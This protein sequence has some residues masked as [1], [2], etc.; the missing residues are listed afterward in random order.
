MAIGRQD[1]QKQRGGRR[2][3]RV[4]WRRAEQTCFDSAAVVQGSMGVVSQQTGGGWLTL[5][6]G[7]GP[8]AWAMMKDGGCGL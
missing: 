4:N 3:G 1:P 2:A 8:L 5:G 6:L 7:R